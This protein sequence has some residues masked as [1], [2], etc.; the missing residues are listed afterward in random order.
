MTDIRTALPVVTV[1]ERARNTILGLRAAEP[2][3]ATLALRLE[4]TGEGVDE[5]VYELT[6]EPMV[7]AA[8][9]D[10]LGYSGELPV[11]VPEAS[12]DQLRG[13]TLDEVGGRR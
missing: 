3:P 2:E 8:P 11:L 7:D 12:V 9:G 10:V 6:F 5:Y 13:A 1:T 4:I